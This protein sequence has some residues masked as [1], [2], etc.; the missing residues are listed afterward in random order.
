MVVTSIYR[1][2]FA[3]HKTHVGLEGE[4]WKASAGT[5]AANLI[6][7]DESI[8]VSDLR[9]LGDIRDWRR[10]GRYR[11]VMDRHPK[12]RASPGNRVRA[13]INMRVTI[14]GDKRL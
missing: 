5:E 3:D 8:E 14:L 6:E 2:I 12:W 7:S 10:I 1:D 13:S 9:R 4:Y 11:K